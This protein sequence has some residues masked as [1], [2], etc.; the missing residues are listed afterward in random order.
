M[1]KALPSPRSA[2]FRIPFSLST[3]RFWGFKSLTASQQHVMMKL[4]DSYSIWK[5]K[6]RKCGE[7]LKPVKNTMA[8]TVCH[9]FAQLIHEALQIL[10]KGTF[11][12][13][14]ITQKW[15]KI[16]PLKRIK[17]GMFLQSVEKFEIT[18]VLLNWLFL[19]S[20]T[21]RSFLYSTTC[22][23]VCCLN[24]SKT[25]KFWSKW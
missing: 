23:L 12:A 19:K 25:G 13:C 22:T 10:N 24:H 14:S 2:I 15:T 21:K 5:N 11:F 20:N 8:M 3:N 9:S 17:G 16:Y 1:V 4:Y 6:T 7:N 18:N